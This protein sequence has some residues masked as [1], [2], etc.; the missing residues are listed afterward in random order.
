LPTIGII[1]PEWINRVNRIAFL[2]AGLVVVWL[3][4]IGI[5]VHAL[6]SY[7]VVSGPAAA[8]PVSWPAECAV[9]PAT[10][11]FTLLQFLHPHCPCSRRSLDE[12]RWLLAHSS[13]EL[14]AI[15]FFVAPSGA[16][17]GWQHTRLWDDAQA[18]P[19]TKVLVD[20]HGAEARR[21]GAKTSGHTLLFD[22]Q[23]QCRFSGGLV[24]VGG[25]VDSSSGRRAVFDILT[26]GASSIQ[27]TPVFG[28]QLVSEEPEQTACAKGES[29]C[30]R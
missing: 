27:R 10:G 21:F 6:S 17:D 23:H 19:R 22:G 18:L 5:G 11:R 3:V 4:P 8:A 25:H 24:G 7:A 26:T 9:Q 1:R 28:C 15:I 13:E 30:P 12:L 2:R 29:A 14:D 16:P 20:H